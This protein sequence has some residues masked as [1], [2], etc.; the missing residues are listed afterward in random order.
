MLYLACFLLVGLALHHFIQVLDKE[1]DGHI[2]WG[3]LYCCCAAYPFTKVKW[4]C[5]NEEI[6]MGQAMYRLCHALLLM[7]V[8]Q[9]SYDF[10]YVIYPNLPMRYSAYPSRMPALFFILIDKPPLWLPT[11]LEVVLS[12]VAY[13]IKLNW[14][15][16]LDQYHINVYGRASWYVL[17]GLLFGLVG[18]TLL[19]MLRLGLRSTGTSGIEEGDLLLFGALACMLL[20]LIFMFDR[21][22]VQ[23]PRQL[24]LTCIM[25][26][27]YIAAMLVIVFFGSQFIF[28]AYVLSSLVFILVG[29]AASEEKWV[30]IWEI[31]VI[32]NNTLWLFA[33][34]LLSAPMVLRV[35]PGYEEG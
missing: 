15:N 2:M 10:C 29:P 11:F 9:A 13:I 30:F 35:R 5:R 31:Y 3:L 16:R 20:T 14:R 12:A 23:Y 1:F 32:V 24:P 33:F 18:S 19:A 21:V 27:T 8:W 26:V 25:W 34:F 6:L 17:L 28:E 4:D 22:L 7:L